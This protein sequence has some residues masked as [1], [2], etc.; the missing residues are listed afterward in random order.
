MTQFLMT[1]P[2]LSAGFVVPKLA[3][4]LTL[5][6]ARPSDDTQIAHIIS[7]GFSDD[8]KPWD[9]TRVNRELFDAEDVVA[10]WVITDDQ[11]VVAVASERIQTELYPSA[12]YVHYVC[13]LAR[14]QGANLGAIL[15]AKCMNGFSERGFNQ[16]VLETDDFRIAAIITYLRLGYIPSYRKMAEQQAWSALFPTL[17]RSKK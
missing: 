3:T 8:S 2:D 17:L 11:G 9:A 1:Q 4:N 5:R 10:T 6:A 15:T 12:G 14:A 7:E 16:A 13:V